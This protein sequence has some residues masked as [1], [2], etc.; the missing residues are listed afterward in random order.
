MSFLE[1]IVMVEQCSTVTEVNQK[2]DFVL[3]HIVISDD[4]LLSL[5]EFII[6]F[7]S[8]LLDECGNR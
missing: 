7:M 1:A 2:V 8:S 5:M 3:T 4:E 6:G